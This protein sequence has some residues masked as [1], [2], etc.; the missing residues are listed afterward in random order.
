MRFIHSLNRCCAHLIAFA[1]AFLE[2]LLRCFRR[3]K[4]ASEQSRPLYASDDLAACERCTD[5]T[6]ETSQTPCIS[7]QPAGP[8]DAVTKVENTLRSSVEAYQP[9]PV[10][11]AS[12][13]NGAGPLTPQ[14][15]CLPK[16]FTPQLS[17][18]ALHAIFAGDKV[19]S[20]HTCHRR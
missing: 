16:P 12:A 1:M 2:L 4:P 19:L 10:G 6:S 15:S 11:L 14:V 20:K 13:D 18:C 17:L 8:S 9:Q 3:R 5:A 7:K